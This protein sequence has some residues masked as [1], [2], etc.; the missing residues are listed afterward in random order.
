MSQE[1]EISPYQKE[2]ETIIYNTGLQA[3]IMELL[4]KKE[5][6]QATEKIVKKIMANAYI[7]TTRDDEKAEMW[8]YRQGIYVPQARTYIKE[9]CRCV[10]L[11][12]YTSQLGNRVIAKIETDTYIEQEELF[13]NDNTDKIAVENGILNI[14]TKKLT[15]YT[16]KKR[17]FSKLPI[18]YKPNANA[19]HIPKHFKTILKY[20]E[21]L[22][23]IEEL[24]GYLLLREYKIETAFMFI[25]TGRNGKSKTLELMKRFLGIDNCSS[26]PLQQFEDD[27]FAMGELFNKMAN[28]AGDLDKKALKH[29]GAFKTLTGRDMISAA[30][31][32]LT[33][34]KFTNYAKLIFACNDLPTTYDISDAFWARW[35][36]LEFPYKFVTQEEYNEIKD[37]EQKA[38]SKLQD[39]E[40]IDKLATEIELSGLLNLALN[41][42]ARLLDNGEFS[43]SK[44][45]EE[46]KT[47]WLRKSSSFQA[48]LLD[49]IEEDWENQMPKAELRKEYGAYCRQ[50][51][52]SRVSDKAMKIILETSMGATE[53]RRSISG[54]QMPVWVGIKLK[55]EKI[56]KV[57]EVSDINSYLMEKDKLELRGESTSNLTNLTK[58]NEKQTKTK[59]NCLVS[60]QF[61]DLEEFVLIDGPLDKGLCNFCGKV[62]T[63]VAE[64]ELNIGEEG[65]KILSKELCCDDCWALEKSKKQKQ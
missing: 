43:Y 21:D 15:P 37:K 32:F 18:E 25:G 27:S 34:V 20:K 6:D 40:I 39:P 5:K 61:V 60:E 62:R 49:K 53:E 31:K 42:L 28:I 38:K 51:K 1:E 14:I 52:L 46:V 65:D 26:I 13:K 59:E 50:H 54:D 47:L 7:Y 22:P 64:K 17:F 58:F 55:K 56:S 3:E 23:V 24:F 12:A 63:I 11:T 2:I 16:P 19:I 44:N 57:S 9:F 10:L 48:F 29:T 33:R 45:T 8:I 36:V 4:L 30:R 35:I 41:G